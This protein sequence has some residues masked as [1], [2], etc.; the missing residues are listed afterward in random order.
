MKYSQFGSIGIKYLLIFKIS[1]IFYFLIDMVNVFIK[2]A[3]SL[4]FIEMGI[5]LKEPYLIM[6]ARVKTPKVKLCSQ[7]QTRLLF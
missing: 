7:M 5:L 6:I 3:T 1:I 2:I 4:Y